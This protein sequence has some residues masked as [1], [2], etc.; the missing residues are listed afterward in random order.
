MLGHAFA[1]IQGGEFGGC[2]GLLQQRRR[3][4][5]VDQRRE[6]RRQRNLG[7]LEDVG[8][9]REWTR[10]DPNPRVLYVAPVRWEIRRVG[11]WRIVPGQDRTNQRQVRREAEPLG[12]RDIQRDGV[13]ETVTRERNVP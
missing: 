5:Q 13:F 7:G 2:V 10:T 8:P 11:G 3:L 9:D 4:L 12:R 1:A 6:L